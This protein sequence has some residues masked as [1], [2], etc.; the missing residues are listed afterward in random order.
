MIFGFVY[1]YESRNSLYAAGLLSYRAP[2]SISAVRWK[3]LQDAAR[4]KRNSRCYMKKH[5]SGP[6]VN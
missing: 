4:Q 1:I 2:G 3:R 5:G 6:W